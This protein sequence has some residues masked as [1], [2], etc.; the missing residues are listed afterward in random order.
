MLLDHGF[1]LTTFHRRWEKKRWPVSKWPESH[2]ISQWF[3]RFTN[4]PFQGNKICS[5]FRTGT[6]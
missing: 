6:L 4:R 1:L 3:H 2:K 5:D